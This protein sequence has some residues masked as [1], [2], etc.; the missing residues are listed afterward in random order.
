MLFH[1][2]LHDDAMQCDAVCMNVDFDIELE[3]EE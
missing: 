2:H 3:C 1:L